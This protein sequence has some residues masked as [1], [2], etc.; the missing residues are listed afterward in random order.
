[1]PQS[2]PSSLRCLAPKSPRV[3][4]RIFLIFLYRIHCH[5]VLPSPLLSLPSKLWI[6]TRVS[7]SC[8]IPPPPRQRS[9]NSN[10]TFFYYLRKW[11]KMSISIFNKLVVV[12]SLSH[13]WLFVTPWT[14]ARQAPLFPTVSWC[15]HKFMSLESVM[16]FNNII[17]CCPFLLFLHSFRLVFL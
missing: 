11:R 2:P 5:I 10:L 15:L 8:T 9:L 13:V 16:L 1:M 12:Q 17:P 4:V 14:A 7:C 6:P 3:I